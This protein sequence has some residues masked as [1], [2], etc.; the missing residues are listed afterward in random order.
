MRPPGIL[1]PPQ[2][3]PPNSMQYYN[4]ERGVQRPPMWPDPVP[5]WLPPPYP[6]P[7]QGN[8]LRI[9]GP[10]GIPVARGGMPL[11]PPG[12]LLLRPSGTP[13]VPGGMTVGP[14]GLRSGMSHRPGGMPMA[15]RGMTIGPSGITKPNNGS[16]IGP[17]GLPVAYYNG[18]LVANDS[19][20]G[21]QVTK[22]SLMQGQSVPGRQTDGSEM[23]DSHKPILPNQEIAEAGWPIDTVSEFGTEPRQNH[24]PQDGTRPGSRLEEVGREWL[25]W[26]DKTSTISDKRLVLLRGLPGSGK[27]TLARSI[28][29]I[30]YTCACMCLPIETRIISL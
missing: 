18:S 21:P 2:Q 5:P 27:S 20:L 19:K 1:R 4:N 14:V 30:Q 29:T 25:S 8:Q 24:A 10:G 9:I 28:H 13:V 22:P 6:P 12:G 16:A 15:H 17:N 7:H 26:T 23:S 11:R 3:I